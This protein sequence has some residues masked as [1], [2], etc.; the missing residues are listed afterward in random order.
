MDRS[1]L[2]IFKSATA[3]VDAKASGYHRILDYAPASVVVVSHGSVR[4]LGKATA[5]AVRAAVIVGERRRSVISLMGS[6][7]ERC[8]EAHLRTIVLRGWFMLCKGDNLSS[9]CHLGSH[10]VH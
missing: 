7:G 3:A 8:A 6:G 4:C 9:Y 2:P 1:R 5:M 10:S